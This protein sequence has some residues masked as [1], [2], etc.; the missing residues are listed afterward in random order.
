MSNQGELWN[1]IAHVAEKMGVKSRTGAVQDIYESK[2][3]GIRDFV[4]AFTPHEGQ[5]GAVF[6]IGGRLVGF[7]VFEHPGV[8][9]KMLRKI[10]RSYALD[11][12]M[13]PSGKTQPTKEGVVDFMAQVARGKMQQFAAVGIGDDLRISGPGITGA[14]LL[15]GGHVVHL[16]AFRCEDKN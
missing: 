12:L 7:E 6:A 15:E 2:S 3:R 5:T 8:L 9:A 14:A 16:C 4:G 10:V 11:A 13:A 1:E